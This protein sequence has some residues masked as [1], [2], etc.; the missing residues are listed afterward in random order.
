M[1]CSEVAPHQKDSV[2]VAVIIR[3]LITPELLLGCTDCVTITPGEPQVF[4]EEVFDLLDASHA[5][6]RLDSGYVAKA[7]APSRVPIQIRETVNGGICISIC[8]ILVIVN[9]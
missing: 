3:P 9:S 5:A 6:L 4:K 1:E 7:A 2:K 8:A